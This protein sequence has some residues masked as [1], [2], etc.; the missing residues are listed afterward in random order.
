MALNN[1]KYIV[2]I[3]TSFT[4]G[5]GYSEGG[6]TI[7]ILKKYE[8]NIPHPQEECAW[9][10]FFQKLINP[11]IK[12]YN[13][14]LSGSGIE[15]MIRT[16]NEWIEKNEDKVKDTLFLL[17]TSGYGR[18]ELWDNEVEKYVVCNW[19]YGVRRDKFFVS[20]HTGLYWR[21]SKKLVDKITSGEIQ[22]RNFL[23]RYCAP[24]ISVE[25]LQSQFF[26]FLCKLKYH[27]IEFKIFGEHFYDGKLQCDKLVSE[28]RLYLDDKNGVQHCGIHQF[29]EAN[30]VQIKHI[31]KGESDDFHACLEGNRQIA[32]QYYNQLK[33]VYNL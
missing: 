18:M 9:P 29:I 28:N 26:D 6:D 14:A 10:A 15:Y 22:V 4:H 11:N 5:G 1:I 25:K 2:A 24:M 3:G 30:E 27:E 33:E 21:D 7:A 8:N 13:L 23:D 32:E 17:E 19:D 12:V 16:V 31:T 20:L